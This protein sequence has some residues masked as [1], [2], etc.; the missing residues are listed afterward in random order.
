MPTSDKR[1]RNGSAEFLATLSQSYLQFIVIRRAT[2][3]AAR[4]S[5]VH[6]VYGLQ[7]N[8]MQDSIVFQKRSILQLIISCKWVYTVHKK[9]SWAHVISGRVQNGNFVF[10]TSAVIGLFAGQHILIHF[11]P[12]HR[13][14]T[15]LQV[16]QHNSKNYAV[17]ITLNFFSVWSY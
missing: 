14:K 1:T 16:G 17:G 9:Q 5:T 6:L 3:W 13:T 4:L 2:M 15:L 7:W 8:K 12:S 11:F 10:A